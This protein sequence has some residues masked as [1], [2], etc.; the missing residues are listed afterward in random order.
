MSDD[1]SLNDFFEKK[2]KSKKGKKKNKKEKTETT[3]TNEDGMVSLKPKVQP[4][5]EWVDFE[6]PKEKD[7]S[8]LKIA[9]LQ[10][11]EDKGEEKVEDE[12]EEKD[13]EGN[14]IKKEEGVWQSETGATE[15]TPT[16][17]P[18][19]DPIMTNVVSGKYVAPGSRRLGMEPGRRK[20]NVMPDIKDQSA[21]PSLGMASQAPKGASMTSGGYTEVTRGTRSQDARQNDARPRLDLGNRFESLNS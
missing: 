6:G 3:E 8:N 11:S 9:D 4:K 14:P 10:I 18:T 12:D 19:R 21:F 16:Q 5:D 17:E 20:A 15:N 2:N 13:D 7:Y 1:E